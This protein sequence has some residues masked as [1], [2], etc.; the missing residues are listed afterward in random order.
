MS[1]PS[2]GPVLDYAS[3]AIRGP[4]RLTDK[5][6]ITFIPTPDGLDIVETLHGKGAALAAI[7]FTSGAVA[8]LGT[9]VFAGIVA[10]DP[11]STWP[12]TGIFLYLAFAAMTI[13]V[14]LAVIHANWRS[15]LL[16]VTR[17][18][19]I[20]DFKSPYR[21]TRR[22]WEPE[23][24]KTVNVVQQ[25]DPRTQRLI[26]EIQLE[27][28]SCPMIRL[29]TGHDPSELHRIADTIRKHFAPVEPQSR[30]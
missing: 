1:L 26:Y 30:G 17:Q 23:Q 28:W 14:I 7:I 8:L 4:L 9:E 2:Q 24:L 19:L 18:R 22:Q 6:I 5:S 11:A 25:L 15:S 3:P 29:F 16:S 10:H 27:F 21:L 20:L 13:L 12:W